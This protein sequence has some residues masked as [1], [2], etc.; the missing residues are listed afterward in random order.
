MVANSVDDLKLRIYDAENVDED[1]AWMAH[2]DMNGDHLE[3][4]NRKDDLE[5]PPNDVLYLEKNYSLKYVYIK[6]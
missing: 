4:P 6:F 2:G 1:E 3:D 5:D